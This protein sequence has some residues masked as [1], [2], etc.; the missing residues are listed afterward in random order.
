[1]T[2]SSKTKNKEIP[3]E[4]RLNAAKEE[5]LMAQ[6]IAAEIYNSRQ[7]EPNENLLIRNFYYSVYHL[8]KCISIID[9]GLNYS[10]HHAL[11]SYFCRANNNHFLSKYDIEL[12]ED[13][14]YGLNRLFSLRDQYDYNDRL[15][16]EEDYLEA[17]GIWKKIYTELDNAC[18]KIISTQIS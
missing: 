4:E 2:V 15:V 17:E 9:S 5:L 8:I 12:G 10:S 13:V 3:K 14:N 6:D 7:N 16:D 1:M 11:I 18:T